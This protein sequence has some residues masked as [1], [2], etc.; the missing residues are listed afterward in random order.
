MLK[1]GTELYFAVRYTVLRC[2]YLRFAQWSACKIDGGHPWSTLLGYKISRLTNVTRIWHTSSAREHEQRVSFSELHI[3]QLPTS[4]GIV[5]IMLEVISAIQHTIE[6]ALKRY[7]KKGGQIPIYFR[8]LRAVQPKEQNGKLPNL[9][10]CDTVPE[11]AMKGC[12]LM[13]SV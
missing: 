2:K 1:L 5:C 7:L 13:H 6:G 11:K 10:S 9:R 3:S 8:L 4:T 12:S